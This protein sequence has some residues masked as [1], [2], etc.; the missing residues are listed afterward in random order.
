[1]YINLQS[2][3][4]LTHMYFTFTPLRIIPLQIPIQRLTSVTNP[5]RHPLLT[6][7]QRPWSHIVTPALLEE[8]WC[9]SVRIAV[10]LLAQRV[11]VSL[12][13]ALVA[14]GANEVGVAVAQ[15]GVVARKALGAD[16]V[17]VAGYE[18]I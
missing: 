7:A 8:V 15:A 17:A 5:S 13:R 12:R 16:R 4:I 18:V 9:D 14:L 11:V 6:G 3:K 10:A 2:I 1:M